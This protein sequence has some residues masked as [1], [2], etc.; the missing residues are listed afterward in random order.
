M[1]KEVPLS[2]KLP[3]SSSV[4]LPLQQNVF[5]LVRFWDVWVSKGFAIVDGIEEV[6][7]HVDL[8]GNYYCSREMQSFWKWMIWGGGCQWMLNGCFAVIKKNL[9][10][11]WP[12]GLTQNDIF[13]YSGCMVGGTLCLHLPPSQD[14]PKNIWRISFSIHT[15][16]A[17]PCHANPGIVTL[18]L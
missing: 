6:K 11:V 18:A 10:S 5:F 7:R 3:I 2:Q 4:W 14:S 17:Q 1:V 13:W 16:L 8:V 9:Q 15:H 12:T